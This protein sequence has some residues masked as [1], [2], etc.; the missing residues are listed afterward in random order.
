MTISVFN[1]SYIYAFCKRT[2]SELD[3]FYHLI[4]NK[5]IFFEMFT[6]ESANDMTLG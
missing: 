5:L 2:R 1:R 4:A 6:H 3:K